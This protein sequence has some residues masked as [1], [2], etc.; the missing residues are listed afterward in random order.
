MYPK[1]KIG[2]SDSVG[3]IASSRF[4]KRTCTVLC[5]CHINQLIS[6]FIH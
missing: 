4:L 2:G 3:R 5:H 6:D 1:E